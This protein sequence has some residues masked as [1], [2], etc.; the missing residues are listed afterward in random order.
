MFYGCGPIYLTLSNISVLLLLTL[1]DGYIDVIDVQQWKIV[2]WYN[3]KT[4]RMA[5][6]S[7]IL[8]K[9]FER[10]ISLAWN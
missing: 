10:N 8:H 4:Y 9:T 5:S 3:V 6:I 2:R 1:G 7:E